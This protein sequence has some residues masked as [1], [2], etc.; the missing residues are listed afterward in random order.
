VRLCE[1]AGAQ[2]CSL[3]HPSALPVKVAGRRTA[4]KS[5]RTSCGDA[6]ASCLE[7]SCLSGNEMNALR[8]TEKVQDK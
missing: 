2:A 3:R 1:G 6:A 5:T 8:S 4:P 7:T